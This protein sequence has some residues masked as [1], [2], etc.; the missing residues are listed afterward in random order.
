M[1]F[2]EVKEE[3]LNRSRIYDLCPA[4]HDVAIATS[5]ADIIAIG[6]DLLIWAYQKGVLDDTLLAEFPTV[7]I[8]AAGVYI[9]GTP[10]LSN[11]SGDLFFLGNTDATVTMSGNAKCKINVAGSANITLTQE[12]TSY[13]QLRTYGNATSSITISDTAIFC[14]FSNNSSSNVL[15]ANDNTVSH[16]IAMNTSNAVITGNND[17]Y[18]NIKA[19]FHSTVE[20]MQNDSSTFDHYPFEQATI[21]VSGV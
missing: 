2:D 3:I 10:T 17:A 8:N 21:E 15:T 9:T 5:Y 19:R 6:N 18:I 1:T 16:I 13:V 14:L 4:F 11:P 7:D 12:D 20:Y